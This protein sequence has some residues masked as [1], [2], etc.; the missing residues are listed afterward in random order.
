MLHGLG[1][2]ARQR[3]TVAV[4]GLT[5]LWTNSIRYHPE[6]RVAREL[7][8]VPRYR[9]RRKSPTKGWKALLRLAAKEA[10]EH[11][12]IVVRAGEER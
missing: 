1:E 11:V 10:L 9:N 2:R 7:M 8:K 4:K 5:L 3:I 6:D 12:S